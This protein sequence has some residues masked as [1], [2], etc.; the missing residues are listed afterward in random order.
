MAKGASPKG[1][2]L[3]MEPPAKLIALRS[4]E[5]PADPCWELRAQSGGEFHVL[6]TGWVMSKVSVDAGV[7]EGVE[8][9]LARALCRGNKLVFFFPASL[10]KEGGAS[11][12]E[13]VAGGWVQQL[14]PSTW[15]KLRAAPT[16]SLLCTENDSMAMQMFHAEPFS[17]EMRS[18][19]VTLFPSGSA[20]PRLDHSSMFQLWR[21]ERLRREILL[22]LGAQGIMFPGVDGDFAEIAFLED[23][24][25]KDFEQRLERECLEAG[26]SWELVSE[27]E[28]KGTRWFEEAPSEG[29]PQY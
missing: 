29:R 16:L 2:S 3:K 12:W 28:F 18:Q 21:E 4:V 25:R 14:R 1:A 26:A 27:T 11:G 10:T 15:D 13:P 22:K 24:L 17:W 7:P 5:D 8:E 20:L 23:P 6:L 19:M 9:V